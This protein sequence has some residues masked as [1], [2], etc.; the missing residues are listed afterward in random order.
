VSPT[1]SE[2]IPLWGAKGFVQL[3]TLFHYYISRNLTVKYDQRQANIGSHT[4]SA[5]ITSSRLV[6]MVRI[7]HSHCRGPGSIPG[8][9]NAAAAAGQRRRAQPP[10]TCP[11]HKPARLRQPH[12]FATQH[13]QG[14]GKAEPFAQWETQLFTQKRR[15][16][17]LNP[18]TTEGHRTRLSFEI[19]FLL[20]CLSFITYFHVILT[21]ILP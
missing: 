10:T 13:H 18:T 12:G 14:Q 6:Y 5:S 1:P 8:S 16:H 3:P 11:A 15:S 17:K 21:V 20:D 19:V 2:S 4:P 9:G 7:R